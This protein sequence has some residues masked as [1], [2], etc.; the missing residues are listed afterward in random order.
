MRCFILAKVLELMLGLGFIS[1]RVEV[2]F[3]PS[4]LPVKAT[5]TSCLASIS[6][7]VGFG[8]KWHFY[9]AGLS[10]H[11]GYCFDGVACSWNVSVKAAPAAWKLL[12]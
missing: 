6:Q 7:S 11:E 12:R 4:L 5:V 3:R 10:E 9:V 1:L 8:T 2:G